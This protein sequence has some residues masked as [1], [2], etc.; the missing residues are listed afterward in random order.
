[1]HLRYGHRKFCYNMYLLTF[2]SVLYSLLMFLD[3]WMEKKNCIG[4]NCPN[5]VYPLQLIFFSGVKGLNGHI[6]SFSIL[7]GRWR[8]FLSAG[9]CIHYTL[10]LI[11]FFI[12]WS[13]LP[14]ESHPLYPTLTQCPI[15]TFFFL[16]FFFLSLV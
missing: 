7:K 9:N 6:L 12:Y 14:W 15:C 16:F 1:M 10:F 13:F 8:V 2:S 5:L 11:G 3:I 4:P